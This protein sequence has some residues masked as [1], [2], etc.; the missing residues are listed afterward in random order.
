MA[1]DGVEIPGSRGAGYSLLHM[2]NLQRAGYYELD[3]MFV[4]LPQPYRPDAFR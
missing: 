3:T 1:R 2:M 4:V